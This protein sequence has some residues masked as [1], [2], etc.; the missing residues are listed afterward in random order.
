MLL[1]ALAGHVSALRHAHFWLCDRRRARVQGRVARP[2]PALLAQPH[3]GPSR[4]HTLPVYCNCC[5][6][7]AACRDRDRWAHPGWPEEQVSCRLELCQSVSQQ[8][9]YCWC[10]SAARDGDQNGKATAY[11]K[12]NAFFLQ[13]QSG[14][15]CIKRQGAAKKLVIQCTGVSYTRFGFT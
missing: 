8:L 2:G 7:R 3:V 15:V 12:Y 6:V 13:H 14:S 5:R 10:S 9:A 4:R 11:T 1:L